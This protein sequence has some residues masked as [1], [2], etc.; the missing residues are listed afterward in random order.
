MH[1]WTLKCRG[2]QTSEAFVSSSLIGTHKPKAPIVQIGDSQDIMKA[3]QD[4]QAMRF[5]WREN[6]TR[7]TLETMQT[8]WTLCYHC[9]RDNETK[10]ACR[11]P[12]RIDSGGKLSIQAPLFFANT[13]PP[14][15]KHTQT[16]PAGP[17]GSE[18]DTVD[19]IE[20]KRPM[21][22]NAMARIWTLEYRCR[23][24]CL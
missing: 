6:R 4:G 14:E 8:D 21:I 22:L 10:A 17:A 13:A 3:H 18:K 16:I 23:S 5:S 20:G 12:S 9:K 15:D 7:A 24:S 2:V 11:K 1:Q 19:E